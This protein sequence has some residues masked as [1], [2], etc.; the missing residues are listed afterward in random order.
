MLFARSRYT[1]DI[2]PNIL[3]RSEINVLVDMLSLQSVFSVIKVPPFE[4][5]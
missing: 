5:R 2:L 1:P 4:L 3:L